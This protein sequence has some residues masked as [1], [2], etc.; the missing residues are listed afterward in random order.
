M[1]KKSSRGSSTSKRAVQPKIAAH[2][3]AFARRLNTITAAN[4][5][6]TILLRV[7]GRDGGDYAFGCRQEG[8]IRAAA[9]ADLSGHR[10]VV[11]A[12]D[13]HV[14]DI[15]DGKKN[16]RKAFL[17]GGIRVQGDIQFA[18]DLA[19]ELGFVKEKF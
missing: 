3:E 5:H 17:A 14:K 16:A 12:D 18:V 8:V 7:K 1:A 15:L 9:G 13:T 11:T 10:L 6:G 4:T 19:Y 2:L